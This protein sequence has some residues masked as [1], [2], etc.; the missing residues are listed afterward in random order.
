MHFNL[1]FFFYTEIP[2]FLSDEECAHIIAKAES[3]GLAASGLFF[4]K[5]ALASKNYTQSK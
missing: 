5:Y 3:F 2:N 4:D 1:N